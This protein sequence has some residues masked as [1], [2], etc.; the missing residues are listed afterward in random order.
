MPLPSRKPTR[1]SAKR[2]K[3]PSILQ[4]ESVE[5]GA[6]SLK[7]I[8]SYF[9]KTVSLAELRRDCGISRDGATAAQLKRVAEKHGMAV[10]ARR[11]SYRKLPA[12]AKF[13]CIIFWNGDHF[14]V[15]EGFDRNGSHAYLSDPARGRT[16]LT[17]DLFNKSFSSVVLELEPAAGFEAN[18]IQEQPNRWIWPELGRARTVLGLLIVLG[19][20][21]G[22]PDLFI[23]GASSQFV[24]GFLQEGRRNLGLPIIWLSGTALLVL[25][26]ILGLQKYLVREMAQRMSQRL[27]A[28]AMF[29][30][31]NQP[32][33]FFAQRLR[34]ELATRMILPNAIVRLGVAGLL[35]YMVSLGS[36][37]VA[38]VVGFLIS[39]VLSIFSLSIIGSNIAL[40]L[41]L[42]QVRL[43]QNLKLSVIEGKTQGKSI[44]ALSGIEAIKSS[45]LE[46]TAFRDWVGSFTETLSELQRQSLGNSLAGVIASTSGFVLRS[47]VVLIG[48]ALIIAGRMTLGELIAFQFILALL[49]GPLDQ[50]TLVNSQLQMLDGQLGRLGDL[51]EGE[52]DPL[53]R[54]FSPQQ[55]AP[56]ALPRA[57]ETA[58]E[59]DPGADKLAGSIDITSLGFRYSCTTP[60]MFSPFNLSIT[61]GMHVALIGGSGSGKS[62]LLKLIAGL[63]TP[64]QGTIHYDGKA[65]EEQDDLL[66][67]NSL[68]YI[69][70]EIFT[71]TASIYDNLTLW[72]PRYSLAAAQKLLEESHILDDIGGATALER[73][74]KE[75]GSDLSGGQRQRVEIARALLREP[76][77]L[78]L[79][80]ATSALDDRT[81]RQ[82]MAFIKRRGNTLISVAHRMYTAEISDLVVV[83]DRG[84]VMQV[85]SPAELRAQ[86][87]IYADLLQAERQTAAAEDS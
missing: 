49:Q 20:L 33:R 64:T 43:D 8:L 30:L 81:E 69:S 70:Q 58:P 27:G 56:S 42:K 50:L 1:L 65:W 80:E 9:G 61:P 54:S 85:G 78:L 79:D 41:V 83:L 72:N 76:T 39:P 63:Y 60:L 36:S 21:A 55:A 22:L 77:L 52:V 10:R 11:M 44:A 57:G 14:L 24:D 38:L 13:P 46:S 37:L 40:T 71:F 53:V 26:L 25:G 2:V 5:C 51:L 7:I 34:G 73:V 68:G 16:R 74:L 12:E 17:R 19:M 86:A 6:V 45:G 32:Y 62:T 84:E 15:L 23:A 31:L 87:G 29:S 66:M 28:M 75:S 48:A 59:A 35:D 47:C 18:T 4:Y 82:V 3:T 67:R